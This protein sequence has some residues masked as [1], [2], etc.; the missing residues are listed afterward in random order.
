MAALTQ[1]LRHELVQ[2]LVVSGY[3]YVCLGALLLYKSSV[4]HSQSIS[5]SP[6]GL[7]LV[8]ALILGKFILIGQ[9]LK[10][11]RRDGRN[12]LG[13]NI[14]INS[15]IFMLLLVILSTIEEVLVG[16]FHGRT[17]HE[18]LAG[19]AG[20]SPQEALATSFLVLLISY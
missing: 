7:A 2:Y 8:K 1:R 17:I 11:G 16:L 10:L 15:V 18:A 9:V 6:Y 14:L 4:L 20:G 3:L 13:L 19:I 12:R 5:Y